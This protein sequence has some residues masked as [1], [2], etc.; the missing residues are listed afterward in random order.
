ME[1]NLDPSHTR[2]YG[3]RVFIGLLEIRGKY[4]KSGRFNKF[5]TIQKLKAL[6]QNEVASILIDMLED[7]IENVKT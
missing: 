5:C 1:M 7:A 6:I 3:M 4:N 2:P